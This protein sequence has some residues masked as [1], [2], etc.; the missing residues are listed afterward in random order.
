[1]KQPRKPR[2]PVCHQYSM[3]IV[4]IMTLSIVCVRNDPAT[5]ARAVFPIFKIKLYELP[6]KTKQQLH[7]K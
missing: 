7:R 2:D 3:L 4:Y 5:L 1:V 6:R